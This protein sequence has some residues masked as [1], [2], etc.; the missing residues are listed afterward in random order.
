V[1]NV[2]AYKALTLC[3]SNLRVVGVFITLPLTR[4]RQ[5]ESRYKIGRHVSH[6]HIEFLGCYISMDACTN[7]KNRTHP[8]HLLAFHEDL[9]LQ[10][11]FFGTASVKREK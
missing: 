11:V 4:S 9:C 5:S 6:L 7:V 1:S 2:V 10:D 8:T 3:E